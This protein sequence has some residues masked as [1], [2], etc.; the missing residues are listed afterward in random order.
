MRFNFAMVLC[1]VLLR[2]VPQVCLSTWQYHNN[3]ESWWG[4]WPLGVNLAVFILSDCSTFL[5][6]EGIYLEFTSQLLAD[7]KPSDYSKECKQMM[8]SSKRYHFWRL[9]I[10][11]LSTFLILSC[12]CVVLADWICQPFLVSDFHQYQNCA[13]LLVV[14]LMTLLMVIVGVSAWFSLEPLPTVGTITT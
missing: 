5:T 9:L 14:C 4:L 3:W 10:M 1:R 12:L 13:I 7:R 8:A 2:T 11:A 6:A